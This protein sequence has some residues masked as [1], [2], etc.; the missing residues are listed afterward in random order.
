MPMAHTP[1]GDIVIIYRFVLVI[2][3]EPYTKYDDGV[4]NEYNNV[5]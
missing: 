5:Q 3:I 2:E 4:N 1:A